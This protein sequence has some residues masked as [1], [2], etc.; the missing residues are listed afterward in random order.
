MPLSAR[1][2]RVTEAHGQPSLAL[3][4]AASHL[5]CRGCASRI[6][7]S[8]QPSLAQASAQPCRAA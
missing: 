8:G 6:P 7:E 4:E 2:Y 3:P 1:S 5:G